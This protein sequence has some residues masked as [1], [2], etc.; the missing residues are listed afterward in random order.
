[1]SRENLELARSIFARWERGDYETTDGRVV[2]LAI[3]VDPQR[4]LR[5]AGLER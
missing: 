4:A 2:E 3:Y 5:D 1:V